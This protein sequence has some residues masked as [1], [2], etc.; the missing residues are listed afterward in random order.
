MHPALPSKDTVQD[1]AGQIATK[2]LRAVEA[3]HVV[4]TSRLTGNDPE[5][6]D[7]LEQ[8]IEQSKPTLPVQTAGL[9]YLLA[10]PFRY[11]PRT[12]GS[13]FRGI[14]DP[15]VFYGAVERRTACFELGS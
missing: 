10:T 5:S 14:A 2:I 1:A 13:R 12:H 3:Q 8:L 4:S 6:H 9:H 11:P 7:L 15:G